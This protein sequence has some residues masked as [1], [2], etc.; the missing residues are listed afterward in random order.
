MIELVSVEEGGQGRIDH[1]GFQ[2]QPP[3]VG[4]VVTIHHCDEMVDGSY[5]IESINQTVNDGKGAEVGG[6]KNILF[7]SRFGDFEAGNWTGGY[8]SSGKPVVITIQGTNFGVREVE[9]MLNGI[10]F[11]TFADRGTLITNSTDNS[12]SYTQDLKRSHRQ[13]SFVAYF[14]TLRLFI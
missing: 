6:V 1:V 14:E 13:V 4:D 3:V 5:R 2:L 7:F 10:V 8:I 12:T 9:V 11:H